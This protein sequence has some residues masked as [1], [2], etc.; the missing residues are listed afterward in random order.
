MVAEKPVVEAPPVPE[1]KAQERYFTL[2]VLRCLTGGPDRY[3]PS[4]TQAIIGSAGAIGLPGERFAHS[5]EAQLSFEN[6]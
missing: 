4:G 5:K 3:E 6:G 1:P 2:H